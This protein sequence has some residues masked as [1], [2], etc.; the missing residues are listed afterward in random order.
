[1]SKDYYNILEVDKNAD[2]DELKK[3]FRK[4]A[5]QYHPD[6]KGGD[7][8]KFKEL[9]EAYQVL[10]NKEKRAQYDQFGSA[11]PG[12]GGQ[13][14]AG[15]FEGFSGF[16]G[17]GGGAGM[18]FDLGDIFGEMFNGGRSRGG[19][20][21]RDI[22]TEIHISFKE[23]VFGV[24]KTISIPRT[25]FC[26]SCDGSGGESKETKTCPSCNGAGKIEKIQR[27]MLG[28]FAT[29]MACDICHASGKVPEKLCK[30]CDGKRTIKENS[31]IT[32][33]VPEG[34]EHGSRLK[35]RGQ[36]EA[37]SSGMTGDL[38]ITILV[39]PDK[40]IERDGVN[41]FVRKEINL[42]DA[43]LGGEVKVET[44]D[45]SMNLKIPAGIAHGELL[46]I[47]DKGVPYNSNRRGDFF[48]KVS[49]KIPKKLSKKAKELIS[50][51]KKEG[52]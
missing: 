32:F 36:G 18:D 21:S 25:E 15:G 2:A 20:Q 47:K 46:K 29:A 38:Y 23:S 30:K 1:M 24:E 40:D 10:S 14:G 49:L 16:G 34:V 7:E 26:S 35:V 41:L 5:H 33:S 50:E 27:T 11:N 17:G 42:T 19:G 39:S 52:L 8:A 48:V 3:A 31:T 9:N 6:K 4:K 28:N 22:G 37:H 12:P 51:L 43:L 45:G 44:L 13:G